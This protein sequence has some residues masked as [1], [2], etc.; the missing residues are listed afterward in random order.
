MIVQI[1][2]RKLPLSE[3]LSLS[4]GAII[5]MGKSADDDLDLL[6]NN[7]PIGTGAAVKVGENFGIRIAGIRPARDRAEA[8]LPQIETAE[9]P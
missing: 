6:V 7:K 9:A 5:E 8:L 4:P 3:I 2:R 1:G